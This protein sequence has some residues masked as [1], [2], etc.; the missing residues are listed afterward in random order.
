MGKTGR[1]E[2]EEQ[3][4]SRQQDLPLRELARKALWETVML[5]GLA[6]AEEAL[7]AERTALCGPRYTHNAER[8]AMRAGHAASGLTW[9]GGARKL[10]VRGCVRATVTN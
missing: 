3:T 5:S 10:S 1:T 8:S 7:E 4:A 9:A 6:F 2:V